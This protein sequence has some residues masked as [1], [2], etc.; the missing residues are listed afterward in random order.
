MVAAFVSSH[1]LKLCT[2]LLLQ[3]LPVSLASYSVGSATVQELLV[4]KFDEKTKLPHYLLTLNIITHLLYYCYD[5]IA[6]FNSLKE[7]LDRVCAQECLQHSV[8]I[9]LIQSKTEYRSTTFLLILAFIRYCVYVIPI[10]YLC[11]CNTI[12]N[13]LY[14]LV[15]S[16]GH[17][18][19]LDAFT[20]SRTSDLTAS[21]PTGECSEPRKQIRTTDVT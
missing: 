11:K 13:V 20:G 5:S 16:L 12:I 10:D 8:F 18:C 9:K 15:M 6:N 17:I 21:E 19:C 2:S 7:T 14:R 3:C 1:P 4:V